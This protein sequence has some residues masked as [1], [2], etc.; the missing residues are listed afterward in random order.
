MSLCPHEIAHSIDS[1]Y[2][3]YWSKLTEQKRKIGQTKYE[4]PI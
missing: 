1:F 3:R 2:K 4:Q